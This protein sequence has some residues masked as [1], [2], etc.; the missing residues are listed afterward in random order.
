MLVTRWLSHD[1]QVLWRAWLTAITL[2]PERLSRELQDEFGINM[3]DYDILVRLSESDEHAL[4]MSELANKTLVSR[5][6]LTHQVD[7]LERAGLVT[8]RVCEQDARGL[9]AQMTDKGWELLQRAAH[10]HVN[11]VREHL[12]DVLTPAEFEALGKAS[13][14]LVHALGA[15]VE[16]PK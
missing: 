13:E 15:T 3:S 16:M 2:V 1:E 7:R 9:I 14:K 11:S 4:R 12:V 8:R 6:R 10:S 5:S